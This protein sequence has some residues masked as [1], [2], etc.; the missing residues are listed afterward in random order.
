VAEELQIA[1][2]DY[3]L[4]PELIAQQPCEPRDQ[5]R[6]LVLPPPPMPWEHRRVAELPELLRAGDLMVMNDSRV[7]PARLRGRRAAT[8]GQW[9]GLFLNASSA[10]CWELLSQTR[11]RLRLGETL[12]V[13]PPE[14]HPEVPPLHLVVLGRTDQRHLLVQPQAHG[15]PIALLEQYGQTPIPPYIRRGRPVPA[16][17]ERYQTI[18]ARVP[19][20]V[21]APTAGL[22]FTPDLLRRLDERGVN[23]AE[24]TLHVGIG[25]F[26]PLRPENLATGTLHQEW[27]AVPIATAE[28]I[29]SAR[30]R[31]SRVIAVG[32]TTTRT[33]ESWAQQ[34]SPP[35]WSGQTQLFIRPGF[36]FQVID[37]L[38]TNFHLPRSSLLMLVAALVGRRRLLDAYAE[39][40]L[41]RYR[42]YSYGDAMLIWRGADS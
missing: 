38:M 4:P 37:G 39:A 40:V 31:G 42:F 20:S 7:V 17:Q 12:E 16:D 13:P 18:F 35:G 15:D 2:F 9:E 34:G 11:G 30:R 19:G 23:R 5:A 3:D 27:C 21:A 33:L 29:A 6:L 8:G 22:H 10:G 41:C 14:G 36:S 24:V 25:T 28:A 1:D 26:A 32:T